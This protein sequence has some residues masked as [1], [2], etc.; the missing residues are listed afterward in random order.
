MVWR[1]W[2]SAQNNFYIFQADSDFPLLLGILWNQ[3]FII[4][5]SGGYNGTG[6]VMLTFLES[7]SL[8]TFPKVIP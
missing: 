7:L 2:L 5:I 1:R 8:T 6:I 4:V 3:F